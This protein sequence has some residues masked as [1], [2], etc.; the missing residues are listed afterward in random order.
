MDLSNLSKIGGGNKRAIMLS[1]NNIS[2]I[3][4]LLNLPI[5]DGIIMKRIVP[6]FILELIIVKLFYTNK[7]F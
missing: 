2:A 6:K 1:V 3:N 7:K 5:M 4:R